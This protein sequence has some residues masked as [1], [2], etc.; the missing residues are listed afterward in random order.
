MKKLLTFMV[1]ALSAATLWSQGVTTASMGGKITDSAG[2]PLP[3][4]SVVVTH[5]PSGSVY[6]AAADF[7]GFYR[8]SGLRPGGPYKVAIT[9]LGYTDFMREGIFIQLG[10]NFRV[11]PKLQENATALEEVVLTGEG[12]TG[13]FS[14]KRTGSETVINN[15]TIQTVPAASR[16]VA[17]F[18]RLT[19]QA[20]LTEG[21]DGFSISLGGANNRYNAIYIDGAVNND[22]FGLAGSGTNGGQTGV[23]PFSVDAIESFQVQ[24]SPYDVKIGGFAGGAI[25]AITR[26][27]TNDWEGS[28]YYFLRNQDL[29][30]KTPVNLSGDDEREKLDEF[31]AQTYGVRLGGPIIKDKLFFFVN[32]ER[33]DDEIPLPFNTDEYNGD[34]G[35][36]LG[37]LASFLQS[38]YNYNPGAA[39]SQ[40]RTLE[41][42]KLTWKLDW[43]VS[44]RNK[45]SLRHSYVGAENLES[46]GS[47][48][49]FIGFENGSEFFETTT[50][51]FA[52][53]WNYNGNKTANSMIIGYT[54]VRDDR[55]PFGD[56]FP[57]VQIQD[58]NG[59]IQ[60]GA[61]RFSTA[62]LLDQDIFTFTN[63]FE[64]YS[65]KHTITLGTHNE[66][67]QVK[68]LFF[69]SNFGYYVFDSLDSFLAS[70]PN[71]IVG[72]EDYQKGYSL[73]GDGTVGDE[74]AGASEF[75]IL[76]LGFYV[77]DEIQF[78][79]KFKVNAGIR[80]DF[81]IWSDGPV[82][83]DFN[84]RTIPLL[85]AAGKDLQG[86]LVGQGPRTQAHVAP[87]VGFNWDVFG[88]RS[89]QI[90]GGFGIFT[91]RMPLVWPGGTYN[92][93]GITGGFAGD[94]NTTITGFTGDV[95]DSPVNVE[96]GTGGTG[97]NIDII[98]RDFKLPQIFKYSLGVDQK[99]PV[100]DL[101]L[102]GDV[103]FGDWIQNIF[104]EQLNI[105]GP[106]GNLAGAD[107]RPVY[108]RFTRIDPDYS[109]VYLLS[110]T[111]EGRTFN[112]TVTLTK[113]FSNGFT[114]FVSWNFNSAYD[115]FPGTSSQN[116][117][118]WRGLLTVNGKNAN[119]GLTRS[120]FYG[121]HR[122][123][124]NASYQFEWSDN[125]KTTIGLTYEGS[126]SRRVSYEYREGT[127]L[128]NDDSR[129]NALIYIPRNESE[130]NLVDR[131][132][133]GELVT[134]AEQWAAL[135]AYIDSN[136]YLSGR[137]G[138]YAER[139]GDRG[140][141]SHVV[142][143]KLLQDFSINVGD[144]KNTLQL[145]ADIFNF[146][147]LLN[148]E[149]GQRNFIPSEVGLIQTVS[150]GDATTPPSFFFDPNTPST[151]RRIDDNGIQSSR[152]QAQ[153]GVRYIFN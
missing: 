27:G 115:V 94:F 81:P 151:I 91:S 93:N 137:R 78:S 130:I 118:Q 56:P 20:R 135:D 11:S 10:E 50:N 149:W 120:D 35:A 53:E 146:T 31:T 95:A 136:D 124:A 52:L 38:N 65:G 59:N 128:L 41:S 87:R 79:E 8:V 105:G 104:Y 132:I 150:R 70:G 112:S 13:I 133:R 29:A 89:T 80:V 122:W 42:N 63:N 99:L 12:G 73:V 16:S 127:D 45:V 58:G 100:W 82:N 84:N 25:N 141:W 131:E 30:G 126:Q 33:Q 88:D 36:R 4:A 97:G 19:P 83:N 139:N 117:S 54:R 134:A 32:Y 3:G 21:N 24:L 40:L 34:S 147:N 77:Q 69:A 46:R 18:V 119:P 108:D 9:Y 2:E 48:Q 98:S 44:D 152:W 76:Q 144:K 148:K 114:G 47:S 72:L 67:S 96:P 71:N 23:N 62:N 43:N 103:E 74:S 142:D 37:E 61:E 145:S 129:D 143:F 107:N 64:I 60:F 57:T 121:G 125:V 85:E 14:A 1:L 92:N 15:R 22:V 6:G 66:Y 123:L 140:A 49:G 7:D 68:N 17:D 28:A 86:A 101:V 109:S 153:I 138:D 5:L 75:D 90:R 39:G 113:P 111:G 102:T 26:S 51:S 106:A 116:S 110:N 55:D